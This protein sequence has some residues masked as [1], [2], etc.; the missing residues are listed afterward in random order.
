MFYCINYESNNC[1]NFGPQASGGVGWTCYDPSAGTEAT[2][3]TSSQWQCAV[4][5]RTK[6]FLL[7]FLSFFR[8]IFNFVFYNCKD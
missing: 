6:A 2:P 3:C 8:S 7:D 5:N 1:N 4:M